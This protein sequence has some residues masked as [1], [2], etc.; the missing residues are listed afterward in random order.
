LDQAYQALWADARFHQLLLAIDAEIAATCRAAGCPI[1][2]GTLHSAQFHRKP[3]GCPAGLGQAYDMR[4]SF[5]CS[6]EGCRKR[7]TPASVRFLARKVYSAGVVVLVS[8]L[9]YGAP[10]RQSQLA[11]ALG[12]SRRTVTRWREWWLTG[13]AASAFWKLASAFFSPPVDA[14]RIPAS[15]LERFAAFV[16]H[17]FC[18]FAAP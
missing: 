12:V 2:S 3:R 13:F 16:H 17:G 8:A 6:Q 7:T 18:K 9:R 11:E 10:R 1:C 15:L 4:C 5:C 14:T